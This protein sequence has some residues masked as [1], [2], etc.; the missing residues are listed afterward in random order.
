MKTNRKI[1]ILPMLFLSALLLLLL[2]TAAAAVGGTVHPVIDPVSLTAALNFA[3]NGDTIL[4]LCNIE[5]NTGIVI[6]E[7]YITIDL[8]G[9]TL[10]VAN[11]S[12]AGLEVSDGGEVGLT[13]KGK[14][15]VTGSTYGVYANASGIATVDNATATGTGG[16]GACATDGYS[17]L[18][19]RGN[20]VAT[21]ASGIGLRAS[22]VAAVNVNGDVRGVRYGAYLSGGSIRI[23]GDVTA[24]GDSGIGVMAS[25][26]TSAVIAGD[27]TA[28]SASGVGVK[29]YQYGTTV[30]VGGNVTASTGVNVSDGNVVTVD[31]TITATYYLFVESAY[32]VAADGVAGTGADENYFLFQNYSSSVRVRGLC[33]I[34]G[35]DIYVT[36]TAALAAAA[37]G[38]TIQLLKNVGYNTGISISG[39]SITFDLNGCTLNVTNASGAGLEVGSGGTVGLTGGGAFNVTGTSYGV[40]AHDGGTATVNNAAASGTGVYI[41]NGGMVTVDEAVTAPNFIIRR[42]RSK[43]PRMAPQEQ[44][45]TKTI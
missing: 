12:G 38:E 32:K 29:V 43:L 4:L 3:N 18:T 22:S 36:L 5:Y 13:G 7:K 1:K 34:E 20:A 41:Q 45:L 44:A 14:F 37:D 8:N 19:V 30:T 9:C 27:V 21:G 15:N 26:G 25:E 31:G 42:A 28:S 33:K 24:S 2:P 39:K 35:K 11:P 6:Q 16:V 10:N 40:Y 23:D 17:F